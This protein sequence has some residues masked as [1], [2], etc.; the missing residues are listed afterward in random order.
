MQ[1]HFSH[2]RLPSLLVPHGAPTFTLAPGAA[3]LALREQVESIDDL[4]AVVI[5]SAHWEATVPTVGAATKLETIYD[6][7]G[8]PDSLYGITY[9]ATGCS[10]AAK[11]VVEAIQ[12]NGLSAKL[13][14]KRGLDHGAWIPLRL[15]FPNADIPIVPLS[16]THGMGA[17]KAYRLGLSLNALTQHGFL[18]IGSGNITHNLSDYRHAYQN[19][20]FTPPKYIEQFSDWIAHKSSP[21]NIPDLLNYRTQAPNALRA[22]PSEEHLMPFYVAMGA[23]GESPLITRFYKGINDYVIAMDAY[24]FTPQ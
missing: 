7:W 6:F 9:P 1:T 12:Q 10:E 8:F 21:I 13:D 11:E 20:T 4:R 18:I 15:M 22:H 2:K 19:Q 16:L 17:D 3:G 23:A 5:V 14:Y 24:R